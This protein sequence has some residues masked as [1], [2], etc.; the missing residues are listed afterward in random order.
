M[1]MGKNGLFTSSIALIKSRKEVVFAITWTTSFATIIA[2]KGFPL[3]TKSFLSIMALMMM[4]LSVYIYN[5]LVDREMDAYSNQEKKKR[6]PIAN[7]KVSQNIASKFIIVTGLLG[8]GLCY[9]IN[10]TVFVI[11]ATYSIIMYLYSY[12]LIRFKTVYIL[13][14][15][16]TSI[17]LPMAFLIGGAA[18]Q[19]TV[20]T[21]MLFLFL[22]FYVFMFSILPAGADCLDLVEDKAFN[23][24][25]I[26]GTLS[27][28][29]NVYLFNFGIL[30]IIAG[31]AISYIF[32][33]MSYYTPIL[34]TAFGLP[35]MKY[36]LGLAK[37]NGE[38][39]A[40]KLRPVGYGFLMLTPLI[41]TLGA[42]F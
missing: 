31:A 1:L 6:R 39:A 23:V 21:T 4:S 26:G 9:M 10:T 15:V 17:V 38:T 20:S 40:Y 22:T 28:R 7:G 16:V 5:D 35:V 30:I 13:K 34:M 36:T 24:K 14:N 2:G 19:N 33:N 41:I 42:V 32:F 29:Q 25:T 37:E 11:G 18:I 8:L 3:I 12:P 27:W